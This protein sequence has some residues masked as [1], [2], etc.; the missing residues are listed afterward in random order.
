MSYLK[1]KI[2]QAIKTAGAK[3]VFAKSKVIADKLE[4]ECQ[5]GERIGPVVVVRRAT[6]TGAQYSLLAC[7][8]L[9]VIQFRDDGKTENLLPGEWGFDPRRIMLHFDNLKGIEDRRSEERRV[10][11][12]RR[13]RGW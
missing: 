2:K 12:E 10:G 5:G 9:R 8:A 13:S 6:W 11:K 4:F 1:E 7:T 3:Q